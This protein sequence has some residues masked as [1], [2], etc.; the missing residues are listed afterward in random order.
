M[1]APDTRRGGDDRP[2]P[3]TRWQDW[4]AAAA[5]TLVTAGLVA[6]DLADTGFRRWWAARPF[7]TGAVTGL[8]V[9]L[10]T[11]LVA[12][13]VVRMRQIRNRSRAV[14][15]QAAILIAQATRSARAVSAALDGSGDRGAATDEVRTYMMMLLVAAPVLID[16][17]LSRNFLEQAQHLGGEMARVLAEVAKDAGPPARRRDRLSEA[18]RRLRTAAD[19]LLQPLSTEQLAA[20]GDEPAD[21]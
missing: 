9:L 12:D 16:A 21:A 14:S 19:P 5:V 11:L 6:A 13:Q 20:A 7:T 1:A 15:A 4:L 10:I 3:L 8:L 17:R 18:V 2:V